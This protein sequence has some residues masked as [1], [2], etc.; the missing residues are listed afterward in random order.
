MQPLAVYVNW[1]AFDE[2]SDTVELTEA[3]AMRQFDELLRLRS[4]H[5]RF[6]CPYLL[7]FLD[8]YNQEQVWTICSLSAP[9]A[10]PSARSS[11]T[12]VPPHP[13]S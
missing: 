3:L 2:L 8:V 9:C 11:D 12:A 4:A 10:L 5:A 7:L 6:P 13:E 1:T